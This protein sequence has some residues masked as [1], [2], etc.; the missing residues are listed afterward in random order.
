ML[1]ERRRED[2]ITIRFLRHDSFS[3]A[4]KSLPFCTLT[5]GGPRYADV[6]TSKCAAS[7]SSFRA[8]P[9][10]SS[11]TRPSRKGIQAPGSASTR[12]EYPPGI[13]PSRYTT[14]WQP[15]RYRQERGQTP[16][17]AEPASLLPCSKE[18]GPRPR[19]DRREEKGLATWNQEVLGS[20][21]EQGRQTFRTSDHPARLRPGHGPRSS[22]PPAKKRAQ[23]G[24]L[25]TPWGDAVDPRSEK[26]TGRPSKRGRVHE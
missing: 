7:P 12:V 3:A 22:L 6:V 13:L 16:Y 8:T 24:P 18:E 10:L 4:K 25:A 15:I 26:A 2:A 1:A 21:V 23:P 20:P 11:E 19:L 9:Y 14:R 17:R 5:E